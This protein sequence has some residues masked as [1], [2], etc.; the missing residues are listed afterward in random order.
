MVTSPLAFLA[1]SQHLEIHPGAPERCP[2][3]SRLPRSVV[4]PVAVA[5]TRYVQ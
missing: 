1:V 4:P 2:R 3:R 5:G